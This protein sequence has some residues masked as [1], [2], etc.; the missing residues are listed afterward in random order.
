MIAI[1][2]VTQDDILYFQAKMEKLVEETLSGGYKIYKGK[3]FREDCIL[4]YT[5]PS[6]VNASIITALIIDKYEPYMVFNVGA[7]YSFNDQLRQG[8]IFIADRYY[9]AEVDFTANKEGVYG[10]IP[11]CDPF[12]VADH[13]LNEKAE[14]NAYLM[15]TRYVQ[16]GFLLSGSFFHFSPK[17]I[18]GV[19]QSHYII[20]EENMRAYDN[21][22]AAI[23][24]V[25]HKNNVALLT[26]KAVAMQMGKEREKFNYIRASLETMPTIGKI[27][28]RILVSR[29][30]EIL[31]N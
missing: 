13:G 2:G 24:L 12:Y 14:K 26:I 8:D 1:L 21:V 23:A 29:T 15:T 17:T 6:L 18:S 25:C 10:Q 4:A 27:I 20:Q 3:I 30:E 19:V 16:R 28:T 31:N 9:F 5:G 11:G 7:V 22:S